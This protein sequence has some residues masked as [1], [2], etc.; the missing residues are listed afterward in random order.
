M[1]SRGA[2]RRVRSSAKAAST[3]NKKGSS[4]RST[5]SKLAVPSPAQLSRES[6]AQEARWRAE[7]DLRVLREAEQISADRKRL[8][9][10]TE[11]AAAEVKALQAIRRRNRSNG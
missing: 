10:A 5:A 1:A 3:T 11:M 8:R 2:Q 9:K 4:E 7:S 6:R